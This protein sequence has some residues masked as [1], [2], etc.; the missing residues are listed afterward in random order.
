MRDLLFGLF[1]ALLPAP[2]RDGFA[3]RHG[4]DPAG[5]SGLIGLAEL[6]GGG[7]ALVSDGL[8]FF[9]EIAERN[10]TLFVDLMEKQRLSDAEK[11]SYGL[12]GVSNWVQ[13]MTRPWTWFLLM[14]LM[15]GTL[16]LVAW[17][18]NSE[19]SGEP[20]VWAGLRLSQLVKRRVGASRDRL[21]FGPERPDRVEARTGRRTDRPE[22][23]SQARLEPADDD[24]DP[25][26]LLSSPADR[27]ASGRPVA[28][29]RLHPGRD[30]RERRHP[31]SDPLRDPSGAQLQCETIEVNLL[32]DLVP[33]EASSTILPTDWRDSRS[34]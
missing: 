26:A 19:A 16:R 28:G 30:A 20:I 5:W 15:V 23:P 18:V 27:R 14:L 25:R 3:H 1:A 21:R 7:L 32:P 24:R 12:S 13:W 22:L 6:F 31:L 10:A 33:Q 11:V 34:R 29:P 17:W 9:K 8:A 2:E 4:I